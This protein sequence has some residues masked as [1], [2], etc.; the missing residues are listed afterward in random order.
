MDAHYHGAME[1]IITSGINTHKT[2][3]F[4]QVNAPEKPSDS[5][6]LAK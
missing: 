5:Y 3:S 6:T 1:W 2:D 4:N